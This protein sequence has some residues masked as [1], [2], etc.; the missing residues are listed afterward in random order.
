MHT[1]FADLQYAMRQLRRSP[2]FAITAVLTLTMAIG[3]NVVVFGVMNAIVL[4]PLPVPD[5]RQVYSLT[6]GT[7]DTSFSYPDYE[8]IRDSNKAFSDLAVAR[9]A[10]LALASSGSDGI[11]QPV[12]GY[13]V[14][15][16][17]FRMLGVQPELGSFF[18]PGEDT[19]VNG[20][21]YAVLSY[22]QWRTQFGGDR[23]IVGK[24]VKINK[25]P[26]WWSGLRRGTSTGR[27]GSSGR[28]C[29]C[30]YMMLRRLRDGTGSASVA[31]ATSGLW[32]V[33]G[34]A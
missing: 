28:P 3:A 4:H 29:G 10:L 18:T 13:E 32:G 14:S 2:V 16:N 9:I 5:S 25:Y 33:C 12:F 15:G 7:T 27:S 8:D 20:E 34:R 6:S 23:S 1:L 24:T 21:P 19:K 30:R 31:P 17:Y 11:A 26:L 22:D